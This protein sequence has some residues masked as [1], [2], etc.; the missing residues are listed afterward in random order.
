[1]RKNVAASLLLVILFLIAATPQAGAD[2][3]SELRFQQGVAA[4]G[5]REFGAAREAFESFLAAN[6]DDPTTLRYLGLISR[7][8]DNDQVAVDHFN[9]ALRLAPTDVLTY[10]ALVET[11]LKAEQNVPA[12]EALKIALTLA[13]Q[14]ARLHLYRGIAEYRLRNL[15]EAIK[16]FE[17]ATALDPKL[18]REARYYTGLAQA[19]LGNLYAA[20]Q[21]FT[22]VAEGSPAHPLGRSARNLREAMEPGTPERRWTVSATTGFEFDTNPTVTPDFFNPDS[23]FVASF[24]VRG[25]VDVYRGG[26]ITVRGGYDGFLLKHID[27]ST[28]DEQ[29]HIAKAAVLYN[30]RNVR[31]SLRYDGSFTLL[32]FSDSFRST[33]VVEPAVS[34]RLGRWGVTQA[35]YQIHR[36]DYYEDHLKSTLDLDGWQHSVGINQLFVPRGPFTHIRAGFLWIDRDTEGNEFRHSGPGANLGAGVLLPWYDIEVSALYRFSH[37]RFQNASVFPK[38]I[39]GDQIGVKRKENIHEITFNVNLPLWNRLSIDVAGAFIFRDSDVEVFRYDR[40]IVGTYLTWDF[41]RKARPKRSLHRD[42]E[43]S[44]EEEGRFPGE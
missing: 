25:L 8:E 44:E 21:A 26:R 28:V 41:G 19:I 4:F 9:H 29:T 27:E 33:H 34:V 16:H 42:T 36:F 5:A 23:D 2:A 14:H 18:E 32:D 35:F 37:L 24:G 38:S 6:P 40:Q 30:Y 11:L 22:E 20:A 1:M 12:Q 10:V 13:P 31:M 39:G 3:K 17:R 43:I 7:H 15:G